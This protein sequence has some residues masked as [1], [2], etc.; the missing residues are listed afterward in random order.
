MWAKK[1]DKSLI[2]LNKKYVDNVVAV[3]ITRGVRYGSKVGFSSGSLQERS[4]ACSARPVRLNKT[5]TTKIEL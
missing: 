4:S 3:W 1:H 2:V 5:R